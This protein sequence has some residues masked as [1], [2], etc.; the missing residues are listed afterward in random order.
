M[1]KHLFFSYSLS[2]AQDI[3]E[4]VHNQKPILPTIP[5]GISSNFSTETKFWFLK[6]KERTFKHSLS[7]K[8]TWNIGA[9]RETKARAIRSSTK[10]EWDFMWAVPKR[11]KWSK[12]QKC[13]KHTT[14]LPLPQRPTQVTSEDLKFIPAVTMPF[15]SI[16]G[17]VRLPDAA[18]DSGTPETKTIRWNSYQ[19]KRLRTQE[20]SALSP[21]PTNLLW[22]T[23]KW[24]WVRSQPLPIIMTRPDCMPKALH[25]NWKRHQASP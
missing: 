13:L 14:A 11:T 19:P 3:K 2:F 15:L 25:N 10:T 6:E 23:A 8:P 20:K 21:I 7:V 4:Y 9:L 5:N 22:A 17:A 12:P 24:T 16:S 1:K 18:S